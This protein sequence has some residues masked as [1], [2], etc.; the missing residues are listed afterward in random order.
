MA[1]ELIAAKRVILPFTGSFHFWLQELMSYLPTRSPVPCSEW[2]DAESKMMGKQFF[3]DSSSPSSVGEFS[4]GSGSWV[5][6]LR[7]LW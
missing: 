4:V 2:G 3:F 6:S 1:A 7:G 5:S